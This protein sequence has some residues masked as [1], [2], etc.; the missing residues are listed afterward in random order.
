MTDEHYTGEQFARAGQ[1][2]VRP[3]DQDRGRPA[4]EEEAAETAVLVLLPPRA[5]RVHWVERTDVRHLK[6][7]QTVRGKL[8]KVRLIAIEVMPAS[9][10]PTT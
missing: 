2:V 1:H 8:S 5:L 7:T 6:R 3:A 10:E 4:A 9:S